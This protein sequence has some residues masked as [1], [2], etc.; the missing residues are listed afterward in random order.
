MPPLPDAL[1]EQGTVRLLGRLPPDL[2]RERHSRPE[3]LLRRTGRGLPQQCAAARHHEPPLELIS[4]S[5]S[6][7]SPLVWIVWLEADL[8]FSPVADF[9]DMLIPELART[10]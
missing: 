4:S 6:S 3:G 10:C 9:S 5:C 1:Q 8:L 2:R 7:P